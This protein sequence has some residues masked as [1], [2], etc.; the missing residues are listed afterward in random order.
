MAGV[1]AA[2]AEKEPPDYHVWI[3]KGEAPVFLKSEGPLYFGGPVW[4]IELAS[5]SWT[6]AK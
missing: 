6:Q 1:A 4:R 2:V 5:P 3:M